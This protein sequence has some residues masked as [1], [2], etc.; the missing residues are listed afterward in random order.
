[1]SKHYLTTFN[2]RQYMQNEDFE[3]FYYE[4]K[5]LAPVSMHQHDFYEIYFF[6]SGN[7]DICLGDTTYPLSYGDI[8][9]IPPA[10]SHRPVFKEN[11]QSYRRIVLWISPSYLQKLIQHYPDIHYCFMETR[12]TRTYH[13][14]TDFGSAQLL[15]GRL[16]AIIEESA[17]AAP[18]HSSITDCCISTFL[19]QLNRLLYNHA[20]AETQTDQTTL[21][22]ELCNYI[23]THLEEPLTLDTL[24]AGFHVSKY[25]IA[26]LF[27]QSMGISTH[28]YI[29]RKRLYA[30]R[31]ILLSGTPPQEVCHLCGFGDYT[32]FFR[33]FKKEFGISPKDFKDNYALTPSPQRED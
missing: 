4:D 9:L 29:L 1:M 24:S 19:L 11:T 7:L 23:N 10:L 27:K 28:Q 14:S 6:L 3:I 12:R 33:A 15:F 32:S 25:H 31:N 17:G 5:I 8:C 20:H 26:H 2:T 22:S 13:Y 18:F 16:I 30:A 21:F